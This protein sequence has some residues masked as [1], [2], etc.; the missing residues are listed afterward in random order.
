MTDKKLQNGQSNS[1]T[2]TEK[3]SNLPSL[4]KQYKGMLT[5]IESAMPAIK[6]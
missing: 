6:C 2:L 3:I 5:H 4:P 1:L